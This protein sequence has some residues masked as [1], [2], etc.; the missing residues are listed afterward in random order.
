M[1]PTKAC[2]KCKTE[3]SL[4]EFYKDKYDK[5][6]YYPICKICK[7]TKA[8]ELAHKYSVLENREIKDKKVCFRCK[9]EKNVSEYH[10]NRYQKHG[11]DHECKDC[12]NKNNLDYIIARRRYDPEFKLLTNLRCRLWQVLKYK[13]K[14]QTTRQ[15][16]GVDFITF[17]KWIKF[18]FEEGMTM[19]ND[20]PV[21]HHDHVLPL[22]SFNLLDEEELQK[23]TNW[24]NIRPMI[25]V[26]NIQKSNKVDQWLY[27]MQEVKAY[28]FLKHLD[29]I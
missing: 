6:G 4:N 25:A 14:S 3:K 20:G 22:S 7:R 1:E 2:S 21:W 15:L 10:K 29:E 24:M 11:I 18:Q 9:V 23:A 5:S 19:R 8:K 26:K 17:I 13:S 28:Y 12:K 27:V 16:L